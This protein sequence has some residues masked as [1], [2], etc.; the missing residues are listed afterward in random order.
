MNSNPANKDQTLKPFK[1]Q[2]ERLVV[3]E[4]A[5]SGL[6]SQAFRSQNKFTSASMARKNPALVRQIIAENT[7]QMRSSNNKTPTLS[8]S[9]SNSV[10]SDSMTVVSP[11]DH[12]SLSNG[13]SF[14]MP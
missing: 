10:L 4:S 2:N 12:H 14:A 1:I 8:I 6:V 5:P 3:A 7:T 13:S 11:G 9:D